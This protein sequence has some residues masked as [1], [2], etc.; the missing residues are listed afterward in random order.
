MGW[1]ILFKAT[2]PVWLLAHLV[3]L[4]T[5]KDFFSLLTS[6]LKETVNI[7][8]PKACENEPLGLKHNVLFFVFFY[9]TNLGSK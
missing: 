7:E 8:V 6:T 4:D 2:K 5:I 3:D 9:N 1:Y